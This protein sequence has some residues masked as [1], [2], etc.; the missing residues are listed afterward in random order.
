MIEDDLLS[1]SGAGVGE[2][3]TYSLLKWAFL[4]SAA[5][6]GT[7]GVSD[8][9]LENDGD[10][11]N[12]SDPASVA[13]CT[14]V[15]TEDYQF[16]ADNVPSATEGATGI[17]QA[18]GQLETGMAFSSIYQLEQ[19]RRITAKHLNAVAGASVPVDPTKVSLSYSVSTENIGGALSAA[20]AQVAGA[21][22]AP[23]IAVLNPISA[24]DTTIDI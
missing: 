7:G 3:D 18:L 22:T 24:W 9:V 5:V 8:F 10:P 13:V 17:A 12:F 2:D 23:S 11:C 21:G 1:L 6:T 20:K 19:L 4:L 15:N 16:A 14:D